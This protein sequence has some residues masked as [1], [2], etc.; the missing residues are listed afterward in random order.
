MRQAF[1]F[2]ECRIKKKTE[3]NLKMK[4]LSIKKIFVNVSEYVDK[5]TVL[6]I[7]RVLSSLS[8]I[9]FSLIIA[10]KSIF[11]SAFPLGLSLIA[12]ARDD[13][14]FFFIGTLI[15][16]IYK[17]N[18]PL[19]LGALSLILL[20][21]VF[22]KIFDSESNFSYKTKLKEKILG[23]KKPFYEGQTLKLATASLSAFTMGCMQIV[24][25]GFSFIDLAICCFCIIA[26]GKV[27]ATFCS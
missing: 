12:S 24:L 5:K 19:M 17:N 21:F 13:T 9:L 6:F 20:R 1:V 14:L 26:F 15:F 16:A 3:R 22:S 27:S 7:R 18:V 25:G 2:D 23:D 8:P 11:L 4:E 10:R